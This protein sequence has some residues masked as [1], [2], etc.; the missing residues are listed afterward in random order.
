MPFRT[1]S[2]PAPRARTMV[3]YPLRSGVL[4]AVGVVLAAALLGVGI[5]LVVTRDLGLGVITG[6]L[7]LGELIIVISLRAR[8]RLEAHDATGELVVRSRGIFTAPSKTLRLADVEDVIVEVKRSTRGATYERVAL[9]VQSMTVPLTTAYFG[10]SRAAQRDEIA[11]FLARGS[12]R[13]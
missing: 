13:A 6:M 8:V 1:A 5:A 7:V 12:D 2:P 11:R 4:A 3:L 9:V 10:G